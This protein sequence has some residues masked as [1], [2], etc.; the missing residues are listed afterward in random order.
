METKKF[1]HL[2]TFGISGAIVPVKKIEFLLSTKL[3]SE[4]L[5]DVLK[6]ENPNGLS[7]TELREPDL[8]K[9]NYIEKVRGGVQ[10]VW[11]PIVEDHME[12]PPPQLLERLNNT[13]NAAE[14]KIGDEV[15]KNAREIFIERAKRKAEIIKEEAFQIASE[16]GIPA[17]I[18]WLGSLIKEC[19]QVR[20]LL[21]E[22]VIRYDRRKKKQKNVLESLKEDWSVLLMKSSISA[23][24]LYVARKFLLLAGIVLLIGLG[25]WI[26]NI[27]VNSILGVTG[28]I[29][30]VL[31]ALKMSW[32]LFKNVG[33]S[34][35]KKLTS[36]KLSSAYKSLSLFELDELTKRLE[37]EYYG[38]M[39]RSHINDIM[40]AYNERYAYLERKREEKNLYL[41]G[42][43]ASLHTV[44]ATIR[45][46]I[47]E[48]GLS[49]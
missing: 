18:K 8:G 28:S 6:D 1:E 19:S 7:L 20:K 17:T 38:E 39:L 41:K 49:E 46:L 33:L 37:I 13:W 40:E 10:A 24:P 5:N 32:P 44:P 30:V 36:A 34:R 12:I 4:V 47:R 15:Q 11:Q 29:I 2:S 25:L 16:K 27:P 35:G 23:E 9:V 26:L 22:D 14:K 48:E 3:Q 42:L 45:T 43:R 21:G 31:L